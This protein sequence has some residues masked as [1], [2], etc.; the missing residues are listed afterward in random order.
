MKINL[1]MIVKNEER[2]LEHCLTCA[3]P[4]VDR[5]IVLDTGSSDRTREIARKMGAEVWDFAWC[6]DFSAARNAALEHSD[7]DWNLVLDGDEY[8]CPVSRKVLEQKIR[9]YEKRQKGV[10]AGAI[11]RMDSFWMDGEKAVSYAW[12]PRLLPRGTRYKGAI[13]EQPEIPG[14][15]LTL[16]LKAE[17]DGYLREDKGKR[18][19]KYLRQEAE[20]YPEDSYY[21]F[22]MGMTLRNL[23]RAEESLSY[24]R[25]FYQ[26]KERHTGYW[27]QGVV[28]YLYALLEVGGKEC[29]ETARKVVEEESPYLIGYADFCFVCGLFYMRLILFDTSANL[30]FLPRIEQCF[31]NCLRIGE[32]PEQGGVEGC[33]SFKAAYNLGVWYEVS[34]QAEK[35]A[36]FYKKSADMGFGPARERLQMF[37]T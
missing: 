14:P 29:L 30:N 13:H 23:K 5:I 26:K 2:S 36:Q 8:L 35:A 21:Q 15:F 32:R 34:G 10:W 9:E 16:P 17:H 22:Q 6:D 12:L 25:R 33:G 1:V 24:F 18:N 20:K 3:G 19:L 37:A 31:L 7:A 11:L 28:L 27:V 4:L